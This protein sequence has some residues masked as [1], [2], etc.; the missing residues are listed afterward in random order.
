VNEMIVTKKVLTEKLEKYLNREISLNELVDWAEK[1]LCDEDFDKKDFELIRDI[2]AR[3]GLAD[4]K[5]FGLSWEDC[6]EYLHLLGHTAT[7]SIS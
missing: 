6:C 2:L 1:M 7:V 4:V 3:L 5:E